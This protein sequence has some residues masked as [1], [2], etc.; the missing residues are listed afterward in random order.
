MV[1]SLIMQVEEAFVALGDLCLNERTSLD[2]TLCLIMSLSGCSQGY[3]FLLAK[4]MK[5]DKGWRII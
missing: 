4:L 3:R 5:L 2:L 1:K